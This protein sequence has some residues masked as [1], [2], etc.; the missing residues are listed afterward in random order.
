MENIVE[1]GEMAHLSNF[2]FFYIFPKAFFFNVLKQVYMEERV[3]LW[4]VL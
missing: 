3:N 1:K 4:A 2:T